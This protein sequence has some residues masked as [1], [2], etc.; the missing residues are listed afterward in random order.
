MEYIS[1]FTY[2][3]NIQIEITPQ[4]PQMK[5]LN[6]LQVLAPVA[7]PGNYSFSIVCNAAGFDTAKE[8][9]VRMQFLSPNGQIL[10]DTGK[11]EFQIPK[12]QIE[13]DKPIVMQF[14]MDMRNLVFRET[15]LHTTKVYVN[16]QE[17]GEYKIPVIVGEYNDSI[18]AISG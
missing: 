14:H 10:H 13:T 7:I 5:I 3:D 17:I 12:E 6:P 9:Y 8:N 11:I 16:D 2:C 15:G 1:S 4:G 18:K